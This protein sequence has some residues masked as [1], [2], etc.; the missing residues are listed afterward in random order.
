LIPPVTL[1][2]VASG[3]RIENVRSMAIKLSLENRGATW[4]CAAY[5]RGL[6]FRQAAARRDNHNWQS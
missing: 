2:A 6:S 5:I 1:R 4:K 3:L